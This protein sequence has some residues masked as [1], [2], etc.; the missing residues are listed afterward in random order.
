MS[1]RETKARKKFDTAKEGLRRRLTRTYGVEM[2]RSEGEESASKNLQLYESMMHQLIEKFKDPETTYSTKL[3]LLTLSPFSLYKT[4]AMFGAPLYMVRKARQVKAAH[5]ILGT[6]RK[7][8]GSVKLSEEKKAEVISFYQ[9][10]DV[11]RVLPG[12]KDVISV[13][14]PD[15]KREN[16]QKRLVL[17]NLREVYQQYKNETADSV[18]FST[19][20][21]LRPPWCVLAGASGTH[22]VCVCIHHQNPKLM[23]RAINADLT[24]VDLMR[25]IVCSTDREEC[26]LGHCHRCPGKG[27]LNKFLSEMPSLTEDDEVEFKQWVSTDR[28]TMISMSQSTEEFIESLTQAISNLTKHHYV[29]QTQNSFLKQLKERLSEEEVIITGDFSENYSFIVQDAVQGYHWENSQATIHPFVSYTR[30]EEGTLQTRSFCVMSDD[31][32]HTTESV[33]TFQTR[34]VHRIKSENPRVKKIHYFTDGCAA[35]Y[36]NRYN[37]RNMCLHK[38]DFQLDCE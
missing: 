11:S 32:R 10:D 16:F 25:K 37:I 1:Q 22:T 2:R 27:E 28:T 29:A 20:A 35:Q 4:A 7:K 24:V 14:C 12:K 30:D 31:T 15:G 36:K 17:S 33:H 26:M 3:Q 6:P 13:R 21:G 5:G 34:V 23:T 18:G 19:F 8:I 38:E 9:R